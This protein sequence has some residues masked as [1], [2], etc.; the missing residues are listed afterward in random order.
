MPAQVLEISPSVPA[1]RRGT[2]LGMSFSAGATVASI[3]YNQPLLDQMMRSLHVN[4]AQI[5]WVPTLTQAGYAIGML[6]LVPLGDMLE[7]KRLIMGATLLSALALALMAISPSYGLIVAGSLIL[8]L[9]TMTPQLLVPFA[10]SLAAPNEKGKVIG[11]M[12]SGILLGILLARTVS[13]FVGGHFGW[14]FMFGG[15]AGFLVLLTL[16]LNAILPT[17][18]PSYQGRYLGLLQSVLHIF[19]TQPVLREACLFGGMLFGSFSA[20]WATLIFLME[21]PHFHLGAEAVGL[22]GL[23]GA[24]A[25]GISPYIGALGDRYNARTMT[26]AMLVLTMASFGVFCL[27]AGNLWGLAAGV[28]LMDL[29]VQCG[30]VSNQSRIFSLLPNAQSRIQTAYM[31]CYFLGGSLGSI[32]GAFAWGRFGWPGVCAAAVLMLLVGFARF[33]MPAPLRPSKMELEGV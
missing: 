21:T 24:A 3:Y 7:R 15:A 33:L 22:Y 16:F 2:L 5:G 6:C 32:L 9:S 18:V 14:R 28:L 25:V 8:G 31:F 12:V 11:T 17:S 13:G 10:A 23:L 29:G 30:H 1:L 19:K 20:F 26:G 4:F 27:C